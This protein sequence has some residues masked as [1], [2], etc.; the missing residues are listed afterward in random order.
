LGVAAGDL[1]SGWG[2][3]ELFDH[4]VYLR[5]EWWQRSAWVPHVPTFFFSERHGDHHET[6]H[7]G[8][9]KASHGD[10][11]VVV[12]LPRKLPSSPAVYNAYQGMLFS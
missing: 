12:V 3:A 1:F 7:T 9:G 6:M 10:G 8:L 4:L 5:K 11:F 2:S